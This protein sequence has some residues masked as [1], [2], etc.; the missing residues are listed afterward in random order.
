MWGLMNVKYII[1]DKPDSNQVLMP[2]YRGEKYLLYNRAELPRLFFVN[3]Y[4]TAPGLD[5]LKNIKEMKFYPR[6]VA[7]FMDDPKI[8][9]EPPKEG[10]KAIMTH[11]G[12]QDLEA[13]VTATGN[14]L[15]FFS[16]AWY[17]EGWK[18]FIDGKESPIYRIDY[19]FRGL[20]VPA[21]EHTISMKFV[22]RGY[23]LGKTLAL[24][25]NILALGGIGYFAVARFTQ[26]KKS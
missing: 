6:D 4:E 5:I 21:G 3:R 13:K 1:S 25:I 18:A 11:Y 2:V 7:Y 15:L 23:Y 8:A 19:M 22:P 17:P 14:N 9:I 26:R 12:I 20:I 24:W 16:E 10:A